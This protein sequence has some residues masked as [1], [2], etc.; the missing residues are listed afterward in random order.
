MCESK[1]HQVAVRFGQDL[2]VIENPN[3]SQCRNLIQKSG[4]GTLRMIVDDDGNLFVWD[5]SEAAMHYD[6]IEGLAIDWAVYGFI[7][8]DGV[9]LE[10]TQTDPAY[11]ARLRRSKGIIHALGADVHVFRSDMA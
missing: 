1:V 11:I 3:P 4:D 7:T 9:G 5:A 2:R 6:V 8:A 10:R